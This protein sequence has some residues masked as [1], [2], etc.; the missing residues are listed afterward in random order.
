MS[1]KFRVISL[2][3]NLVYVSTMEEK[4]NVITQVS[5]SGLLVVNLHPVH[6]FSLLTL[7]VNL[8]PLRFKFLS[9]PCR[10]FALF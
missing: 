8:P 1:E 7:L 5:W 6:T 3:K 2:K 9:L 10:I 4:K